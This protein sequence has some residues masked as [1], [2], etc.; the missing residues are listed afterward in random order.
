MRKGYAIHI[1]TTAAF[2]GIGLALALLLVMSEVC[3]GIALSLD[4][5]IIITMDPIVGVTR[6]VLIACSVLGLLTPVSTFIWRYADTGHF[7]SDPLDEDTDVS[8]DNSETSET[9]ETLTV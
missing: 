6:I 4:G 9:S 5:H 1:I 8:D 7:R 3:D 2:C